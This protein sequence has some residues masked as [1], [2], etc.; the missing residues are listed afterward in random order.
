M[1]TEAASLPDH[2]A[3]KVLL[4][5][6]AAIAA[7]DM[8]KPARTGDMAGWRLGHDLRRAT[9]GSW[10]LAWRQGKTGRMTE[11]GELWPEV[12]EVL[13]EL[14]LCGRPD[15]LIHLR[16]GEVIGKTG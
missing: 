14:I 8:N 7:I 6:S 16:Y 9:D 15:R 12:G 2:S 11:A 4:L 13:D 1:R 10:R 3:R 5:R